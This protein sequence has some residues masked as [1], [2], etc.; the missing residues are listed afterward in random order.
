MSAPRTPP[1]PA[2]PH[3]AAGPE[4]ENFRPFLTGSH[5]YGT[6]NAGSDIDLVVLVNQPEL[7]ELRADADTELQL[8]CEYERQD[9]VSLRFG[10]LN[11]I[12]CRDEAA[13]RTWRQGTEELKRRAPVTR[14]AA[15]EFMAALRR[16]ESM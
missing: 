1:P 9:A 6:P 5:A 8:N 16:K 14:R 15:I 11:L 2:Y 12:C 7:E 10:N 3:P 13:Y 4:A